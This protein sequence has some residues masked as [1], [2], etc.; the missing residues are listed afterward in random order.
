MKL[1]FPIINFWSYKNHSV[2]HSSISVT[3]NS[4]ILKSFNLFLNLAKIL[5]LNLKTYP[6]NLN[7]LFN[8]PYLRQLMTLPRASCSTILTVAAT[9]LTFLQKARWHLL[10]TNFWDCQAR[11]VD[12]EANRANPNKP[13]IRNELKYLL[14]LMRME[15]EIKYL[16]MNLFEWHLTCSEPKYSNV[17]Q[18]VSS[19]TKPP[20]YHSNRIWMI[21]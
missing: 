4:P 16:V 5:A 7:N 17:F 14:D 18:L 15:Y 12:H 2:L 1:S 21:L 10:V 9:T 11:T 13:R 8:E 3:V 20:C 19:T 6:V